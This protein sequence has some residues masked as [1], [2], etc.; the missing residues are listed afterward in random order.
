M[1][2]N[3]LRRL[4]AGKM[5]RLIF[6]IALASLAFSACDNSGATVGDDETLTVVPPGKMDDFYSS[7]AQEYYI[8]GVVPIS[9][10]AQWTDASDEE[11]AAE[12]A[13]LAPLKQVMIAWFLNTYV[14]DKSE[15]NSNESYGGFHAL[16]KNGSWEDLGISQTGDLSFD[17]HFRQEIGG[18]FDVL[19]KIS[20]SQD[21]EGLDHFELI[22][23]K[24]TNAQ[25][26]KLTLDK[27]WYRSSP[28]SGF[29]PEK[30]SED[31]KEVL[32]L[33][34]RPEDRPFDAWMDIE[35]LFA[36]GEVSIGLHFGWDYHSEYHLKHSQAVFEWL[37]NQGYEAPVA[38]E[39]YGPD[40]GDLTRTITANG[41][42]VLVK[43]SLFW[44]K[45]GT[46]TD[47]DTDA[48]GLRLE[49]DMEK[50]F[51]DREVIVFNGHSGAFYGFALGNWKKTS[52]G[53]IDDSEI[54]ELEMPADTYQIVLAEGCD[55]FALGEAFKMNPAKPDGK[56]IDIITTTSFSNASTPATV[57]DF[58]T[59]I[60]GTRYSGDHEPKTYG[61]LL[62]DMD[63][64]TYYFHTMYGVH[65]IDDNPRLH[66][67]AVVDAFC[68][69]CSANSDCGGVGNSCSNLGEGRF[70]TAECTASE[71]CPAG[72]ECMAA[73]SGS[74]ITTKVCVPIGM[75]CAAIPVEVGPALII[76]EILADPP[77][78]ETGDANGDG[79]R[80]ALD[81]EF[82]ELVNISDA[83]LDL[84]G[85]TITDSVGTRFTFPA[86]AE[87]APGW[88][89]VVFG[90]GEP[91]INAPALIFATDQP[92]GL[93]NAGDVISLYDAAGTLLD[94]VTYGDEGGHGR[95]LVRATDGDP[96]APFVLHGGDAPYSAGQSTSGGGF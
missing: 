89:A 13:R 41:R 69:T 34:I 33:T 15:H 92:L 71:A 6:T 3:G 86:S 7:S 61:T 79:V 49:Q 66:P 25:L 96:D 4:S 83:P 68:Q 45:P 38:Y 30:V 84:G 40:S 60:A 74:W 51:K 65:S 81:D 55:T 20:T 19:S 52:Y 94:T 2:T 18:A 10:D 93:N 90:G 39:D 78:D 59:A 57:K 27:E 85:Y 64:N 8:E 28:W 63:S 88:A 76:N 56:N 82:I 72:Y 16:T 21:D 43:I 11:R 73:A 53:D 37:V 80:D 17:F 32:D 22:I 23:G 75:D 62:S 31:K 54:P 48:G 42:E 70:C 12:A 58:I 77:A 36:D 95:S 29:D 46:E 9:L 50:S 47:P 67:Y 91:A 44:G 1:Y 24:V 5:A 87:L 14:I 26:N 35:R